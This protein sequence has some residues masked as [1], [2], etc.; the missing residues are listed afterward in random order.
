MSASRNVSRRF[1]SRT[2][3]VSRTCARVSVPRVYSRTYVRNYICVCARARTVCA[4]YA[5]IRRRGASARILRVQKVQ[6][7][8]HRRDAPRRLVA[9]RTARGKSRLALPLPLPLAAVLFTWSLSADRPIR[10]A[11][12]GADGPATV[13]PDPCT[14]SLLRVPRLS[15]S[16]RA[17]PL[18][19]RRAS[20]LIGRRALTAQARIAQF[21][22]PDR[23]AECNG[24]LLIGEHLDGEFGV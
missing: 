12:N 5:I 4:E 11:R 6:P 15:R 21:R 14:F 18:I 23:S 20:P 22:A 3:R 10:R 24:V 7:K 16:R 19:G 17:P 2:L 8:P 1:V 9:R 13:S